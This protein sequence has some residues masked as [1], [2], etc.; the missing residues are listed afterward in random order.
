MM[1]DN[2]AK[3]NTATPWHAPQIT[4]INRSHVQE[5]ILVT[6]KLYSSGEGADANFGG[7]QYQDIC[8]EC[9]NFVA[10]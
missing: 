8:G 7:C 4:V 3:G 6:C 10:S 1:E 5:R 9:H 2:P